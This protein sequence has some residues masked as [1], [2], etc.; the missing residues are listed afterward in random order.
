MQLTPNFCAQT[1]YKDPCDYQQQ[2]NN[3]LKYQLSTNV[4]LCSAQIWLQGAEKQLS[5][6]WM[7]VLGWWMYRTV[8]NSFC[9]NQIQLRAGAELFNSVWD[10][11]GWEASWPHRGRGRTGPG[12]RW[13][14]S[15]RTSSR[16]PAWWWSG[17]GNCP[18]IQLKYKYF[19]F[20]FWVNDFLLSKFLL[21]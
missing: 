6:V 14:R 9:S 21:N 1:S 3:Q 10:S 18:D 20:S 7:V 17:P 12:S 8:D 15:W 16:A 13:R 11:P 4:L 5:K 2:I 19:Q